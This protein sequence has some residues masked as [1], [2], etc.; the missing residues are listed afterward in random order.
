MNYTQETF[1]PIPGFST[2]SVSQYGNVRNR[3]GNILKPY[4]NGNGYL[5]LKL[6]RDDGQTVQEY[7][8][9]LVGFTW[10]H[11]PEG[12]NEVNHLDGCPQNCN[13]ANL[14]WVSTKQ[15]AEFKLVS[16]FFTFDTTVEFFG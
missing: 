16:R 12:T 5:K 6:L 1:K 15:N 2:Y 9:R 3:F 8:H 7:L 13:A 10:L 4:S 11:R 14:E